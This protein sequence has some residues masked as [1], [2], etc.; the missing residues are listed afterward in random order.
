MMTPRR[1]KI[2]ASRR[3]MGSRGESLMAPQVR[4][5][6]LSLGP[7]STTPK[8]VYSVPQS[9]PRTRMRGSLSQF[10]AFAVGNLDG[11]HATSPVFCN[12]LCGRA[13]RPSSIQPLAAPRAACFSHFMLLAKGGVG[14]AGGLQM[15]LLQE[16]GVGGL[17]E[18]FTQRGDNSSREKFQAFLE[19]AE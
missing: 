4:Q 2:I 3:A 9:T 5:T 15:P 12:R 11:G 16:A 8:P 18:N 6:R 14:G 10:L 13:G 1:S 17:I 7:S 19:S